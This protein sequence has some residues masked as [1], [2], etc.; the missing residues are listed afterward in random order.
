MP[1]AI[2]VVIATQNA[3]LYLGTFIN[4]FLDLTQKDP[5]IKI[6]GFLVLPPLFHRSAYLEAKARWNLYGWRDFFLICGHIAY[7]SLQDRLWRWGILQGAPRLHSLLMAKELPILAYQDINGIEFQEFLK[8]HAEVLISIACPR[9][10]KK[11]KGK[12]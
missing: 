4:D 2:R 5:R 11:N 9:I 1:K 7:A 3:P 10:L 12:I 8:T 6:E